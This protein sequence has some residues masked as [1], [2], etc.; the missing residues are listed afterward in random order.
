MLLS[1]TTFAFQHLA[2]GVMDRQLEYY[3]ANGMAKVVPY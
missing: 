3:V 2:H 1:R